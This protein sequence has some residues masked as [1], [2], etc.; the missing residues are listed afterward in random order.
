MNIRKITARIDE[1]A[2]DIQEFDPVIAYALDKISDDLEKI[3]AAP[4]NIEELR[5]NEEAFRRAQSAQRQAG[6][7]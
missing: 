5:G 2:N 3:A 7:N 6:K 4:M 1:L